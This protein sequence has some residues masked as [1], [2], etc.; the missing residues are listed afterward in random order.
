MIQNRAFNYPLYLVS[1]EHTC[2]DEL[3]VLIEQAL[4]GGVSIIQIRH[5]NHDVREFIERAQTAKQV[6][7]RFNAEHYQDKS[8]VPLIINDRVDV[9]LAVNADGVHL[10]QSDMPVDIARRLIGKDKILGLTVES[11]EQLNNAQHFEVD[12]LG[13]STIFNTATKTNTKYEWKIEGLMKAVQQSEKPLVAIGGITVNN[14]EKIA[15]T[16]VDSMALVSAICANPDPQAA[17]KHL[18]ELMILSSNS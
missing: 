13:I 6:I 11:P 18:R 5:K 1:D 8:F 15:K 10:G 3:K 7:D 17:A 4:L 16:G 14:I 2:G 12:Y 9:A